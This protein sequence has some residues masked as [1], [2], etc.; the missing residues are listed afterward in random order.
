MKEASGLNKWDR[1]N[2]RIVEKAAKGK[3]VDCLTT[4]VINFSSVSDLASA[5]V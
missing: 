4:Y 2:T 3:T 1:P 5:D